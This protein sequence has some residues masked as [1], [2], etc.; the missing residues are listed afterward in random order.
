MLGAL[1]LG[2]GPA[3]AHRLIQGMTPDECITLTR[4]WL[5]DEL[6]RNS[7]SRVIGIVLRAL[8]KHT[9][10]RFVVSYADPR[11]GHW[12]TIYAAGGWLYL[13]LS[14]GSALY[15]LDGGAPQHSRTVAQIHGTHSLVYLR[16]QGIDVVVVHQEPKHRYLFLLDP[17]LRDR[18]TVPIQSYPKKEVTDADA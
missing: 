7:E 1:T 3:N 14:E 9:N 16:R 12:G 5:A 6:P 2:A 18:L 17:E 10:L 13:G 11:A 15:S 8:R 4:F